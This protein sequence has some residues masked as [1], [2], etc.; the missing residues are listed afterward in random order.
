MWGSCA[1]PSERIRIEWMIGRRASRIVATCSDEVQEL[2]WMG[3]PRAGISVAPSGVDTARF[4][5]DGS[6][7]VKRLPRRIFSC[8][9]GLAR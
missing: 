5:P 2:V 3:V 8:Q 6:S 9:P 4:G 1:S 7:E